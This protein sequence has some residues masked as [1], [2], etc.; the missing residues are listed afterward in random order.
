MTKPA[1]VQQ[2]HQMRKYYA[3]QAKIYDRTRWSFLFGRNSLIDALP[4]ETGDP[5]KILEVGCGT[6]HNLQ[7]LHRR[8]P[9]AQ[10]VGVDV[11]EDMLARAREKTKAFEQQRQLIEGA[12]GEVQLPFKPN[13]IIFS[14]CLTMV[15]PHWI[16]LIRQAKED[17]AAAGCIA[18]VDFHESPFLWFKQHMKS[19]HVRMEAHILPFLNQQFVPVFDEIEPAYLGLWKYFQFIGKVVK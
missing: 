3:F 1:E 6:G 5:I 11:S 12:Y 8:F 7:R 16:Q 10:L 19:H 15:N 14:Y 9:K 13:V 17:L 2:R 4:F 18:V